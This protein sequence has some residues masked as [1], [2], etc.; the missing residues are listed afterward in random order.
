MLLKYS[1]EAVK[2]ADATERSPERKFASMWRNSQDVR[3]FNPV[4]V[5]YLR[6]L[7]N[8]PEAHATEW[9]GRMG[10]EDSKSE[11]SKI[12]HSPGK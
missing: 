10:I 1:E 12:I 3:D 11:V 5:Q 9:K 6:M 8:I 4:K 7:H 2:A